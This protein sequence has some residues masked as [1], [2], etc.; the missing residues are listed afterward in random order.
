MTLPTSAVVA[1]IVVATGLLVGCSTAPT[2]TTE[3][4]ELSQKATAERQEWY[5]L[6][7][8][9]EA[10]AKKSHGFAFFPEI[11]KGG[12]VVGGAYGRGVVYEQGQHIGYADM[13]PGAFGLQAEPTARRLSCSRTRRPWS[14]S[15]QNQLDFGANASGDHREDGGRH[16]RPVRRRGGGVR[17]ADRRR[18]GEGPSAV[19]GSRTWRSDRWRRSFTTRR[20]PRAVRRGR[21]MEAEP[22]RGADVVRRR[23]GTAAVLTAAMLLA[24]GCAGRRAGLV[25]RRSAGERARP[26]RRFRAGA[27]SAR[28]S[29]GAPAP[30][31][32]ARCHGADPPRLASRPRQADPERGPGPVSLTRHG[33][34]SWGWRS[35]WT[36]PPLPRSCRWGG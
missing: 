33:C 17:A 35:P 12:L 4:D 7:P 23:V 1:A 34:A 19:S 31:S 18:H 9:I 20:S 36:S 10:L 13:T 25:R 2:T 22:P 28:R 14:A 6:D 21:V 3:R 29:A 27:P 24:F 26:A 8:G 15:K 32:A 30:R 5:K 16:E 11:G